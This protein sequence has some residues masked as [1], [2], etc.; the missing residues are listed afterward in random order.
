MIRGLIEGCCVYGYEISDSV[1]REEF[2]DKLRY[3]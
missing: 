2:C 1:Y 3:Y